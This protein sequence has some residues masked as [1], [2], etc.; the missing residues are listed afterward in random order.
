[1]HRIDKDT[2]GLIVAAK[3]DAAH[4]GLSEQFAA[5]EIERAYLAVCWGAPD[6]ADPRVMGLPGVTTEAGGWLRVDTHLDRHRTDRKR[7]AV[8]RS[9]GK[10]AIT[11]VLTE[12]RAGD[13]ANPVAARIVC[14]LE[15]GRTHQIRVHMAWMGHPLVGD[16]VYGRGSRA[17]PG[18]LEESQ[19][20]ALETFPR[21]ALH[22]ATLGFAH[23][24]TGEP[25]SFESAPPADM[26]ALMDAIGL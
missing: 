7:M 24:V 8:F 14:R 10:R 12:A 13:P 15:T 2:S 1:V 5:H 9:G 11:H 6:A 20:T 3:S 23:P 19:R 4:Q 25:L 26:E 21:Q 17:A 22:A 18:R 16:P